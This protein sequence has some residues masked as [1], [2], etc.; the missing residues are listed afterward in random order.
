MSSVIRRIVIHGR[1]Q[2]V[3]FRYWAESTARGYGLEG[4]VRNRRNGVVEVVLSGPPDIVLA[5]IEVC[6]QGPSSARV[7]RI[8]QHD[9]GVDEL[10]LRG[11]ASGFASLP[12][13]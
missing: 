11:T 6:R 4:W 10:N 12:T 7:T 1:V 5:M 3:G 13:V 2:G 8:D 9:A